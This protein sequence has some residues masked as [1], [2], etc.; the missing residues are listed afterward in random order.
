MNAELIEILLIL[1]EE[2]AEVTQSA[3]KILRFGLA[4]HN[5]LDIKP[6]SNVQS[7]EQELGDLAA[8]IDLLVQA[9]MGITQAGIDEA[10]LHK[11]E[12]LKHWSNLTFNK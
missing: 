6:V 7:L 5:P 1:Q 11:F 12:K 8:M 2:C 3:S 10:K 4:S 9:N